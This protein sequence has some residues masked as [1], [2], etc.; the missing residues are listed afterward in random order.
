MKK[1][2]IKLEPLGKILKIES[3][4]SLQDILFDFGIEFPCGGD[5]TCGKCKIRLLEGDLGVNDIQQNYFTPEELA[6]GWRLACQ[7]RVTEPVTLELVQ[8]E[9]QILADERDLGSSETGGFAVVVDLGTTTLVAQLINL[10]SGVISGTKTALNPQA[11]Y[12]ADIMSRIEYAMR[13][14]GLKTLQRLIRNT[15]FSMIREMI[16]DCLSESCEI[17]QVIIVGNT[18]MHHI[19]CG[20]GV[21]S[22]SRLPFEAENA[23]EFDVTALDIGWDLPVNPRIRF[24]PCL[25][26]FVGSDVLAGIVATGLH[27]G[28]ALTALIDLGTNGEVVIGSREQILCA[29]TAAGPAFEGANIFMGM[30]ATTG[31]ISKVTIENGQ[32]SAHVIGGGPA[33][34]I[35]GSGLVDAVAAA[36]DLGLIDGSGRILTESGEIVIQA[37]VVLIQQDIR[38]LQLAKAAIAAGLEILAKRLSIT[39]A[40]IKKLYIAGAFGNYIS[41]DNALKIGLLHR[42]FSNIIQA[43]NTALQGA[44]YVLGGKD[45]YRSILKRCQHISLGADIEFMNRYVENM[46]FPY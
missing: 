2:K 18:V 23:A 33:K 44:K 36:I 28:K 39:L 4:G 14:D 46:N 10:Q 27:A 41:V 37:P 13:P 31:A 35:C 6:D 5:G 3:G 19:F 8:W 17:E 22:L 42:S 16:R 30:R 12:G 11:K 7:C 21:S 15:I 43:G 29:S 20:F 1:I 26:G 25:G 40:D 32:L 38:E 45:E 34:G 24:L 9:M